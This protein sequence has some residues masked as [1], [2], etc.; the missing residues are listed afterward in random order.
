MS[1]LSILAAM[2]GE[3]DDEAA[4]SI[5]AE[6]GRRHG[7]IVTACNTLEPIP[8]AAMSPAF[9]GG[10]LTPRMWQAV[11]EREHEV[12]QLIHL[13]AAREAKRFGLELGH[14]DGARLVVAP[15]APTARLALLRELPLTDLV[16]VGG[17]NAFGAGQWTGTLADLLMDAR[18]P[19]FLAR[20]GVSPYGRS[21][22]VAWDGSLEAGRAVRAA[23]PLLKDASEVAI[24]QDAK[25]LDTSSGAAANPDRLIEFLT[26]HGVG[27]TATIGVEG[28]KVG[29]G[30]LQGAE[31]FGAALLVAGAYRHSRLTEAIFGGA[32]H[33]FL[34]ARQGPHML[35]A[36]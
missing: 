18:M 2:T 32:T 31:R 7:S 5:A 20:D 16:V 33:S 17:S 4:L 8:L 9:A 11:D 34:G 27:V 26:R 12:A 21:A 15:P 35:I 10:A 29:P 30:L 28:H 24:L 22:A 6:L 19:I 36:H 25:G 14:G 1:Y 3:A 13:L 23:L